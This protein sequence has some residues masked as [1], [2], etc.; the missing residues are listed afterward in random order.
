MRKLD[1]HCDGARVMHEMG[2][3]KLCKVSRI[4]GVLN[5]A[6]N[7]SPSLPDPR[8]RGQNKRVVCGFRVV[9]IVRCILYF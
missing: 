5:V 7:G 3:A 9:A 1:G 4:L 2:V 6:H 8:E